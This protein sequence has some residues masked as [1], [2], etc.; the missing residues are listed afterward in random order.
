MHADAAR[1]GARRRHAFARSY[2][3]GDREI[4]QSAVVQTSANSSALA[5]RFLTSP[6]PQLGA[7]PER[8]VAASVPGKRWNVWG[9]LMDNATKQ[10]F[11]Y[12]V[13]NAIRNDTD[14]LTTTL[15]GDYA[16]SSTLVAGVSVA[17]DRA[18]GDSYSNGTNRTTW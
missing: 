5:T 9:S 13:G 16:L 11:T 14:S 3:R 12:A 1:S 4:S 10:S 15:G 17:F 18:K 8:G 7:A 2:A 6:P